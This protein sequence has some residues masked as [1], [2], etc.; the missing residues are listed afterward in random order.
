[1]WPNRPAPRSREENENSRRTGVCAARMKGESESGGPVSRKENRT[2]GSEN[3]QPVA[4]AGGEERAA[5]H[6]DAP[7]NMILTHLERQRMKVRQA[8]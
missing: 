1:M 8:K 2:R 3:L 5:E 7:Q 6:Q 4:G